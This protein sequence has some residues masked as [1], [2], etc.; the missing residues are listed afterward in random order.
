M[1]KRAWLTSKIPRVRERNGE[2]DVVAIGLLHNTAEGFFFF[3]KTVSAKKWLA[4]SS[5]GRE[6]DAESH[7]RNLV[8]GVCCMQ[9][10]PQKAAGQH[11]AVSRPDRW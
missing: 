9:P 10:K 1:E 7:D 11:R 8:L 3:G 4:G 2:P 6:H 5:T